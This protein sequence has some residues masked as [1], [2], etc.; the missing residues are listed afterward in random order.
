MFCMNIAESCLLV[1]CGL[2]RVVFRVK[3]SVKI[4]W[5]FVLMVDRNFEVKLFV[6]PRHLWV[7]DS[8]VMK[9]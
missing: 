5:E 7:K 1:F 8:G 9:S 6:L 2:G 3:L 4:S